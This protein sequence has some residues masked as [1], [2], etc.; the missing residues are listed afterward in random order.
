[1]SST[2]RHRSLFLLLFFLAS[3]GDFLRKMLS[4]TPKHWAEPRCQDLL[5]HLLRLSP[6]REISPRRKEGACCHLVEC[7]SLPGRSIPRPARP[8]LRSG[9]LAQPPLH[10]LPPPSAPRSDGDQPH[11]SPLLFLRSGTWGR[12]ARFHFQPSMHAFPSVAQLHTYACAFPTP[13]KTGP[14]PKC[15]LLPRHTKGDSRLLKHLY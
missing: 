4:G 6:K 11:A 7:C 9:R 1:M 14:Q 2:S 10:Q 5:Q 12:V 8:P 13:T 3:R 15:N